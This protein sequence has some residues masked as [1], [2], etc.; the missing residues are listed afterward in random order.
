MR[1]RLPFTDT[2][3]YRNIK[4]A[5]EAFVMANCGIFTDIRSMT[6]RVLYAIRWA[7]PPTSRRLDAANESLPE[8]RGRRRRSGSCPYLAIIREQAGGSADQGH[9][10]RRCDAAAEPRR[11]ATPAM[12]CCASK[13]TRP[14]LLELIWSYWQEEGMLVQTMNALARRFQN[15][16]SPAATIRW[17]IWRSI[18][19]GR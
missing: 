19:C 18:R 14:C 8:A 11:R 1:R 10:H 6:M 7:S 2:D 13:L 5:T 4:V 12:A 16:R 9:R 15:I 3:A 17:P